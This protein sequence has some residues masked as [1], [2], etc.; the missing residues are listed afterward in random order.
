MASIDGRV[1]VEWIDPSTEAQANKC[2][3]HDPYLSS[4]SLSLSLSLTFFLLDFYFSL[5]SPRAHN[6]I[7][8]KRELF[9][10]DQH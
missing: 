10:D 8:A 1:A 6:L 3:T 2:V 5:P 9:I 7:S 4:A